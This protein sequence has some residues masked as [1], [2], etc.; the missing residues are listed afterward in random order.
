MVKFSKTAERLGESLMGKAFEITHVRP[1]L[2]S[3]L[4]C[5]GCALLVNP[6]EDE[7]AVELKVD[8]K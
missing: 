4:G 6:N 5:D 7:T 8:I 1:D 2:V 3:Q